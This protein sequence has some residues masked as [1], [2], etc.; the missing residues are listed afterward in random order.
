VSTPTSP[1]SY[2]FGEFTLD[3]SV[4]ELQRSGVTVELQPKP[5]QLLVYLIAERERAV[6]REE[7]IEQI[8]RGV[9]VSEAAIAS[10]LRDLRRALG[11]DGRKARFIQTQRGRGYRFVMPV[12][13]QDEEAEVP[14]HQDQRFVGRAD[15]LGTLNRALDAALAGRGRI[16]LIPGAPGIGKTRIA[17]HFANQARLRGVPVITA[18]CFEGEE[19]RPY[20]PWVQ[21][22]RERAQ[23]RGPEQLRAEMGAAAADLVP[24]LPELRDHWPDIASG[25]PLQP[26]EARFRLFEGL[27]SF[28][29]TTASNHGL[30]VVIDDLHCADN[31]SLRLL[32]FIARD[33]A[34]SRI[35][36]IATYRDEKPEPGLLRTLGELTRHDCCSLL[37]LDGL[38]RQEVAGLVEG[39]SGQRIGDRALDAICGR[40]DG[41]P[42]F[43]RELV[44]LLASRG[45]Q[46][47]LT[48]P[49]TW[50]QEVPPGVREIIRGR[51]ISLPTEDRRVLAIAAVVGRDFTLETLAAVTGAS[52]RKIG[53]SIDSGCHLGLIRAS[54]QGYRFAHG[55]IQEAIYGNLAPLERV[56][57]HQSVGEALEGRGDPEEQLSELARHFGEAAPAP[58]ADLFRAV[59]YAS[60]A[61]RLALE[62]LAFDEAEIHFDRALRA[63]DLDASADP[64][65]R[66]EL[67]LELGTTR[68]RAG[69]RV[70]A[71]QAFLRAAVMARRLGDGQRLARA[72]VGFAGQPHLF[73][74]DESVVSFLEEALSALDQ[75]ETP[76]RIEL[77]VSLAGHLFAVD[78]QERVDSLLREAIESSRRLSD[79]ATTAYALVTQVWVLW[80]R[81]SPEERLALAGEAIRLAEAAGDHFVVARG[82]WQKIRC[83]LE[84][85]DLQAADAEYANLT[86]RVGEGRRLSMEHAVVGYRA[87]RTLLRGELDEAETL[88]NEAYQR[89]QEVGYSAAALAFGARITLIRRDQNRLSEIVGAVREVAEQNRELMGWRCVLAAVYGELGRR[90]EAAAEMELLARQDFEDLVR[91]PEWMISFV[92]L[93]ELCVFLGDRPRGKIVYETLL[94][95]ARFCAVMGDGQIMMGSVSHY[96]GKLAHLLGENDNAVRHLQSAIEVHER[97]EANSWLRQSQHALRLVNGGS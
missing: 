69:R 68:S 79:P 57:L 25:P 61:G 77:L 76:L 42:F 39:I 89:G 41:N 3:V 64:V 26:E 52:G 95:H 7:L 14:G 46:D 66:C 96:L 18:W 63:M 81:S 44:Q 12:R 71:E 11:D 1:R 45:G 73:R 97:L 36:L 84:L 21:V 16:S 55:L 13:E 19:V 2:A 31:S 86:H 83:F 24:L 65:L 93:A 15:S 88:S 28:L 5:L 6:S 43:V 50:S 20:W 91:D 90:E 58:G 38:E 27:S 85:G 47:W 4:P 53:E 70:E 92:T 94:P 37:P 30:V 60:R 34:H 23:A 9:F 82:Q 62:L 8:W 49:H 54:G 56:R 51:L 78:R 35:H 40:T 72:A 74:F 67:W 33:F 29:K 75:A 10:A 22:L 59:D 48:H 17:Q 80:G 87:M 32:E